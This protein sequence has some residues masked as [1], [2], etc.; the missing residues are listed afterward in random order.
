VR[1]IRSLRAMWRALETGSSPEDLR[2]SARPY[3]HG[4]PSLN[5][6][7]IETSTILFT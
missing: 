2:A 4:S 7:G 3:R 1:E 5:T 6:K